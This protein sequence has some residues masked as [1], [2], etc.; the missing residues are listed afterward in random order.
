MRILSV[1]DQK[2]YETGSGVYLS[3]LVCALKELGHEQAVVA[4]IMPDDPDPFTENGIGFYPVIFNTDTLNFP[5]M[6]MSDE[7]PY[8]STRYRDM[9]EEMDAQLIRAYSD[10]L[11]EAVEKFRPELIICHH[12]YLI[13]AIT[14]K[15]FPY[16]RV[17]GICHGSCLRQFRINN[18]YREYIS[19][20]I[21]RLDAVYALHKEQQHEIIRLFHAENVKV[22]GSAID[23]KIYNNA[24]AAKTCRIHDQQANEPYIIH[25]VGKLS[26]KKG[27]MSLIKA[28]RHLPYSK[29]KLKVYIA[30]GPGNETEMKEIHRLASECPFEIT[31]T[32][33]LNK[34]RVAELNRKSNGLILPSYYEGLPLVIF[35]A[36]A[37]GIPVVMTDLPGIRDWV[38]ENVPNSRILYVPSPK[39]KNLDEPTESDL[40]EFEK[41]L[42]DKIIQMLSTDWSSTPEPDLSNLS[43]TKLAERI[44]E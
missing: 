22:L 26:Y 9:T 20:Y 14:R 37:C 2:P 6:G 36:M 40:P 4:G 39:M 25:Y 44:L 35:E 41:N 19:E 15:L 1:I 7:M 23:L 43:W 10:K 3:N 21:H 33:V 29:D 8:T 28:L 34:N 5:V 30:G 11:F 18:S 24:P 17:V 42:A 32:G 13:T 38:S 12:L 31:F 16:I 27:V